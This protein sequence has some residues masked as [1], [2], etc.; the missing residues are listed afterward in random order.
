MAHDTIEIYVQD[1]SED[2]AVGWLREVF[3]EIEQVREAPIV[4]YEGQYE[5]TTVPVQVTEHVQGGPYTSLWFNAPDLPW[6][7]AR[8][9]VRAA[10]GALGH[11]VL[12]YLDQPD[13]P[14][15]LLR[16]TPDGTEETV[17]ERELDDL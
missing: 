3:E 12:C 5:G 4:T 2:E 1:L 11:E 13:E 8:D 17:D 6:D 14:W 7:S 10:H 9:C 15:T 16:V